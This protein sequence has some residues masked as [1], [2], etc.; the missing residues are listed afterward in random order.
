[1]AHAHVQQAHQDAQNRAA[2]KGA[3]LQD[4][5]FNSQV[6]S[7]LVRALLAAG[8]ITDPNDPRLK[9]MSAEE[10][11]KLLAESGVDP[12]KFA[13]PEVAAAIRL[14][15]RIASG[16]TEAAKDLVSVAI[17]YNKERVAAE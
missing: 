10:C 11:A 16:D 2:L 8:I 13:D 6:R 5:H 15:S 17:D 3:S 14:A 1:M 7:S 12:S 9:N 4:P